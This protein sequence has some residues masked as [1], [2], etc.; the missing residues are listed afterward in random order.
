MISELK[1][2]WSQYQPYKLHPLDEQYLQEN[3]QKYCL[4][5]SIQE[6]RQKYGSDLKSDLTREKFLQDKNNRNKILTNMLVVPFFGD[7][8][9]AKIYI[10]MGNPGFHTGDYIDEHEDQDYINLTKQNLKLECKTFKSLHSSSVR[11]GG[12]RYWSSKGRIPKIAQKLTDLNQKSFDENY[13]YV[14][15]SIAIVESIAYHS[16]NKPNDEL[17]NLPSSKITKRLV[18]EY[19]QSRINNNNSM[20]FVWRSVRFWNMHD[21]QNLLIRDPKQAQLSMFTNLEAEKMASYLNS[22]M[23]GK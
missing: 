22:F 7:I 11:T 6:I 19:I 10:L 16:C 3:K 1:E 9:N 12:Y 13:E 18:N 8:E 2:F 23:T 15:S 20:C 4:D 14:K 21:N 17:Y 5:L